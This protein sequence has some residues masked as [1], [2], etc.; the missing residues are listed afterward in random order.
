MSTWR[1]ISHR[2]VLLAVS[3][4][5]ACCA[6][7]PSSEVGCRGDAD[8]VG[9]FGS[10]AG[11]DSHGCSELR[12]LNGQCA[13]RKQPAG[14][15]PIGDG[16]GNCQTLV[17]VDGL[18][19]LVVDLGDRPADRSAY[20]EVGTCSAD[21]SPGFGSAPDGTPCGYHRSCTSGVCRE[22]DSGTLSDA[23]DSGP[24]DDDASAEDAP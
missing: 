3:A 7:S 9:P 8:C 20:C 12:C 1:G 23:G 19:K 22:S 15:A 14:P 18:A 13:I 24:G 5:V 10:L 11:P 2:S 17:C 16:V 4:A 21:G 6:C